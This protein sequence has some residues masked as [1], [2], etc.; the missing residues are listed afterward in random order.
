[1]KYTSDR[2]YQDARGHHQVGKDSRAHSKCGR[3][4]CPIYFYKS[5]PSVKFAILEANG[6]ENEYQ[7]ELIF[8]DC[9]KRRI[10]NEI[11]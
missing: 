8:H 4:G 6:E 5:K 2:V 10:N 7:K 11:K 3:C 1:M 9:P